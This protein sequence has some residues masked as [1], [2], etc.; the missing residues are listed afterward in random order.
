MNVTLMKTEDVSPHGPCS[1]RVQVRL[2]VKSCLLRIVRKFLEHKEREN[3]Y[4]FKLDFRRSKLG[5]NGR[6]SESRLSA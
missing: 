1:P 4:L 6:D 3:V 5:Q 2:F